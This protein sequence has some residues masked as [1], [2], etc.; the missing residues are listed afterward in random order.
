MPKKIAIDWDETELRVVVAQ[1][2]GASVKVTDADVLPL[3]DGV[4]VSETLKRYAVQ[5][6]LQ[7]TETLVAIGRG[8]AELRELQLPPVPEDELPD[9]VRFQAIRSFASASDRATVDYLITQR[10][11]ENYQMIAAAVGPVQLD[12]VTETCQAS[13]LSPKR[14]ALRPLAAAALYLSSNKTPG[15]VVM[16]DLLSMDAEIV[17][18]RD[19]DVIFVRT[20]RLPPD[21]KQRSKGLAGELRRSLLACGIS[22]A[23]ETVI[24]WGRPEVH[25]QE[26]AEISGSMDEASVQVVNPFDLVSVASKAAEKLPDHVGRLAPLV[27]LL[28]SDE[29]A[30]HRLIDFLNPRKRVEPKPDHLRRILYIGGPIAAILLLG[31]FAYRNISS[32]DEKIAKLKTENAEFKDPVDIATEQI[33]KTERVDSFLDSGVNWLGEFNYLAEKMPPSDKLIVRSLSLSADSKQDGGSLVLTGNMTDSAVNDEFVKS[34]RDENHTVVSKRIGEDEKAKDAYRWR[35]EGSVQVDGDYVRNERYKK[36][37][38]FEE[39]NA[40]ADSDGKASEVGDSDKP[41]E[42]KPEGPPG[43]APP[44]K[45]SP[46]SQNPKTEIPEN[47]APSDDIV[48]TEVSA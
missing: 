2:S 34:V 14:I 42:S 10:T 22:D 39:N 3:A 13:E 20:V 29:T 7:K 43:D 6:E 24:L 45:E 15:N 1:C 44:A 16:I 12:E 21:P 37:V 23:P 47:Q 32:L 8:Q 36:M 30:G 19:G 26:V 17:I 11:S 18:A 4:S 31:F 28:A 5:H 9:M 40:S 41:A 38:L 27:G 33:A 35:F 46:D 48:Q 25:E